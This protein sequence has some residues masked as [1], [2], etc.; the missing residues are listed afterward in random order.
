MKRLLA[1]ALLC[2]S[3]VPLAEASP[4]PY[5]WRPV[6]FCGDRYCGGSFYQPVRYSYQPRYRYRDVKP[7]RAVHKSRPAKVVIKRVSKPSVAGRTIKGYVKQQAHIAKSGASISNLVPELA[8][9]V[10]EL[11]RDCGARLISGYRPGARV[12]SGRLSLH[13]TRPARAADIAGNPSCVRKKMEGWRGGMSTDYATAPVTPHYH[14]S[15][16]PPNSGTKLAGRE[17]GYR[18]TH[19]SK[20]RRTRYAYSRHYWR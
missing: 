11:Q 8:A 1:A 14:I 3:S 20:P 17:W 19:R 4:H 7:R 15:W 13:S 18:F 9:K 6:E 2:L 12:P 16:S 10:S 5:R